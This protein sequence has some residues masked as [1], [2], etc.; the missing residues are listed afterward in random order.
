[1]WKNRPPIGS[2]GVGLRNEF[3]L[4]G[5]LGLLK[6]PIGQGDLDWPRIMGALR[7]AGHDPLLA[8]EAGTPEDHRGSV[9]YLK[10]LLDRPDF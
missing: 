4:A 3:T 7:D 1:M 6:D 2:M 9:R 5:Y 10:G 8:I